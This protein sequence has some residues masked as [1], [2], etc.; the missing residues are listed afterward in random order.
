MLLTK[1]DENKYF[2]AMHPGTNI[3]HVFDRFPRGTRNSPGTYER[4]GAVLIWVILDSSPMFTGIAFDNSVQ[5]YFVKRVHYPLLGEGGFLIG[6]DGLPSV[7]HW[8][9]IDDSCMSPWV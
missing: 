3:I 8:M 2:G 9:H 5:S 6:N 1:P 7:L 4:F